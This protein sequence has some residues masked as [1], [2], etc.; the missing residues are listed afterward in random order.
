[1][2]SISKILTKKEFSF[3][4][5][6][7]KK[8][9][10]SYDFVVRNVPVNDLQT[11]LNKLGW[12]DLVGKNFGVLKFQPKGVKNVEPIDIALPRTEHA[13]FTGG[14][15][16]FDVKFDPKLPIEEDLKRRDFTINALAFDIKN[17]K[18]ID[19][20]DGLKDI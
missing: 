4:K 3:L 8:F 7:S 13:F 18:L 17:D 9:S 15:R 14:Y 2:Q 16:D 20:F 10:T 1:M 11:F 19:L 5:K 12:V 6:L